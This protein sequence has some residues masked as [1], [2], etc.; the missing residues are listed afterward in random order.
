M[1]QAGG[2]VKAECR[3]DRYPPHD[4]PRQRVR[5][6]PSIQ[7]PGGHKQPSKRQRH[8]AEGGR[9]RQPARLEKSRVTYGPDVETRGHQDVV[10]V[11]RPRS[12]TPSTGSRRRAGPHQPPVC[13]GIHGV[14]GDAIR[15]GCAD[16]R[17][18]FRSRS[19]RR[20]HRQAREHHVA[21]IA[22]PGTSRSH[23]L[24]HRDASREASYLP[25]D[26]RD[27]SC[28]RLGQASAT[29]PASSRPRIIPKESRRIDAIRRARLA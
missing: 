18:A 14:H 12:R 13:R 8:E 23:A 19:P 26:R 2:I 22:Y 15:N 21:I 10:S 3:A 16:V 24:R 6:I 4:Q 25:M 29:V 1:K 28:A 17:Q 20:C 5:Q 27:A 7:R 11:A 9:P